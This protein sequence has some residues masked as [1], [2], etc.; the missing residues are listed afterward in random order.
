MRRN[1]LLLALSFIAVPAMAGGIAV[2][3][4]TATVHVGE[5]IVLWA[6]D[7]PGGLSS[8]YP[9]SATFSSDRAGV[10]KI[11]GFASGSGYLK[12]DP[13]PENGNVYVTGISPGIAHV[14]AA[15]FVADFAE[16]TVVP[17]PTVAVAPST[18]TVRYGETAT[19]TALLTGED[20]AMFEWYLGHTGDYSHFLSA[21]RVL[22]F[23]PTSPVTYVWVWAG[24]HSSIMR[25]EAVVTVI[26]R[27]RAVR[28]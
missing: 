7:Y 13:L 10:A 20:N 26:P 3:P 2:S 25:S 27:S 5:T 28:H 15:G 23:H 14:R 1:I 6:A 16:V 21:D 8:G 9:Y 4:S 19:L 11:H 18:L 22:R 24:A 12:P 17:T